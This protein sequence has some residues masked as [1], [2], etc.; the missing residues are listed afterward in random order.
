MAI[1]IDL[2]GAAKRFENV[3]PG[4][5]FVAPYGE[6]PSLFLRARAA[7]AEGDQFGIL[8]GPDLTAVDGAPSLV[9]AKTF[10]SRH[11]LELSDVRMVI[12]P[13]LADIDFSGA[14]SAGSVLVGS[15]EARLVVGMRY[16]ATEL[17]NLATGI[18]KD[19]LPDPI[20]MIKRWS[21]VRFRGDV[22]EVIMS[23]PE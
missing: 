22:E 23:F 7:A 20:V 21:V 2:P 4:C 14:V 16:G 5:V 3:A 13:F 9:H 6:T 18:L 15:K 19:P 11:V 17:V 12:S 10:L 1:D 8:L